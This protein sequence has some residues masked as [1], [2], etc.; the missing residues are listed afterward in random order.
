MA[1]LFELMWFFIGIFWVIAGKAFIEVCACFLLCG[2]FMG[3]NELQ[4]MRKELESDEE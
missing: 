4:I 3:V 2:I 1:V